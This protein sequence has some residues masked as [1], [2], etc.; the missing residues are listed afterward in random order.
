MRTAS[1]DFMA[2]CGRIAGTAV[3]DGWAPISVAMRTSP[4]AAFVGQIIVGFTLLGCFGMLVL[5]EWAGVALFFMCV[6]VSYFARYGNV[7]K[8]SAKE[9]AHQQ[10]G[11]PGTL[12]G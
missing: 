3:L 6:I 9:L 7:L 8:R 11:G 2:L 10:R 4:V 1:P 12:Q 5:M